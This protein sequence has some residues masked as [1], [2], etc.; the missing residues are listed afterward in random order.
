MDFGLALLSRKGFLIVGHFQNVLGKHVHLLSIQVVSKI[1][2]N[3]VL[4]FRAQASAI[5]ANSRLNHISWLR[6]FSNLTRYSRCNSRQLS[7]HDLRCLRRTGFFHL[8]AFGHKTL[9]AHLTE[10]SKRRVFIR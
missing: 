1:Q 7:S 5:I 10:I 4:L 9:L 2:N 3:F 6:F 8:L